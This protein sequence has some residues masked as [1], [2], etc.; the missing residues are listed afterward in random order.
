MNTAKQLLSLL[1]IAIFFTMAVATGPSDAFVQ[2]QIDSIEDST[3]RAQAQEVEWFYQEHGRYPTDEEK[4]AL[5]GEPEP[6]TE[7]ADTTDQE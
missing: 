5:L 3:E 6:T 4:A 7:P 1:V 2:S